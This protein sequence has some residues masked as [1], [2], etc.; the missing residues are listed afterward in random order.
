M[1]ARRLP[2]APEVQAFVDFYLSEV[3]ALV[4]DVGYIPVPQD[5]MQS[6]TEEWAAFKSQRTRLRE[7][8]PSDDAR[9]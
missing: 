2:P 8:F 1:S 7:L 5:M 6:E 4:P 9:S 3:N